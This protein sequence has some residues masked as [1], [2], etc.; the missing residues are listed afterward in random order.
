MITAT[1]TV[2]MSQF[3]TSTA[4]ASSGAVAVKQPVPARP[5]SPLVRRHA[6]AGCF[7]PAGRAARTFVMAPFAGGGVHALA[8]WLPHLLEGGDVALMLQY[9]DPRRPRT[10]RTGLHT[11]ADDIAGSLMESGSGPLVLIGHSIGA[12]VAYELASRLEQAGRVVSL[13]VV[14][15]ARPPH[16]LER[17]AG[18]ISTSAAA[19]MIR[20][21]GFLDP[22]CECQPC[23]EL[24]TLAAANLQA[25]AGLLA[26]YRPRPERL[27]CRV[28]ALGGADDRDVAVWHLAAWQRVTRARAEVGAFA[29]GHFF[30]RNQLAPVCA[31]IRRTLDA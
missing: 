9:A 12:L 16:L 18:E 13:L 2:S 25:D 3:M 1:S 23:S 21:T 17:A 15:A 10:G 8:D 29:G 26:G 14:A 24:L 11:L 19:D 20:R 5:L 22:L 27:S 7:A 30:Y 4:S 6:L 31:L 28:L